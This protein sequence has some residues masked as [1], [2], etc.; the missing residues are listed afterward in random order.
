MP[1]TD[2]APVTDSAV[3]ERVDVRARDNLFQTNLK[4]AGV[5]DF[6][7]PTPADGPRSELIFNTKYMTLA[8]YP[9]EEWLKI[10]SIPEKGELIETERDSPLRSFRVSR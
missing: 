7:T 8:R 9:N 2:W 6:G 3:L 5:R 10:V 1:L 4:T